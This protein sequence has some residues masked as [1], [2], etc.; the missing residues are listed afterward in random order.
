[1]TDRLVNFDYTPPEVREV[2]ARYKRA[3]CG[4]SKG[5]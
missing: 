5:D 4:A 2:L 1:V 3:M